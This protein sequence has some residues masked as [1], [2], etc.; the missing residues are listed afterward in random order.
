MW[1]LVLLSN[2]F[3]AQ[4]F[5]LLLFLVNQGAETF[6]GD[7]ED[8][9][10]IVVN[11]QEA[12]HKEN[13]EIELIKVTAANNDEADEEWVGNYEDVLSNIGDELKNQD[14]NEIYSL[15]DEE[16]DT[17]IE[18]MEDLRDVIEVALEDNGASPVRFTL[19]LVEFSQMT[20]PTMSPHPQNK[21]K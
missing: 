11:T 17:E 20:M 15:V 16:G 18:T 5:L 7:D 2:A 14:W 6:G 21:I 3:L 9:I 10:K 1:C 4:L 19:K 13:I 12:D 8:I